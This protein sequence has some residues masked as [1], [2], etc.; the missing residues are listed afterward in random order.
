MPPQAVMLRPTS[1]PLLLLLLLLLGVLTPTMRAADG[2]DCH[3]ARDKKNDKPRMSDLKWKWC[4]NEGQR[5][6]CG[7]HSVVRFG[8]TGSKDL[9]TGGSRPN[10]FKENPQVKRWNYRRTTD[11]ASGGGGG[12]GGFDATCEQRSF[13]TSDEHPWPEDAREAGMT[14]M[15]QC[16]PLPEDDQEEEADCTTPTTTSTAAASTTPT[17]TSSFSTALAASSPTTT[18]AP[19]AAAKVGAAAAGASAGGLEG[20]EGA[21]SMVRAKKEAEYESLKPWEI[22]WTWCA[23]E[24]ETCMC[25]G[26]VR[27]GHSGQHYMY[28]DG[29]QWFK[30]NPDVFKWV[31]MESN[32]DIICNSANFADLDPFPKHKKL[33]QCAHGVGID[34][35]VPFRLPEEDS[36]GGGSGGSGGS[37]AASAAQLG[38]DFIGGGGEG[39]DVES[40]GVGEPEPSPQVMLDNPSARASARVT[41]GHRV[42]HHKMHHADK[43]AARDEAGLSEEDL[44]RLVRE[45][46]IAAMKSA[47]AAIAEREG[48]LP[49]LPSEMIDDDGE[50]F[51]EARLGERQFPFAHYI[52]RFASLG[53]AAPA[54][55]SSTVSS[56]NASR[57]VVVGWAAVGVTAVAAAAALAAVAAVAARRRRDESVRVDMQPLIGAAADSLVATHEYSSS[58]V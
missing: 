58:N 12:G 1:L 22:K 46:E 36:R 57:G 39:G 7:G 50:E 21:G 25:L 11:V 44:R 29:S 56:S 3:S 48:V 33:C 14:F 51:R 27:Y 17:T 53:A 41:L 37:G 54:S 19:V 55:S 31:N 5:C 24:G 10:F 40:G 42:Y 30:E 34:V 43:R 13:G 8:A 38:T 20:R 26:T 4:A 18:L 49:L 2:V 9:Y 16:A 28:Q 32:G 52:A 23:G 15:C 47:T 35:F 6:E 45:D